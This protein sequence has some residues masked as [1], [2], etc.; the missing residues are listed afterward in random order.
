MRRALIVAAA[1]IIAPSAAMAEICDKG[2][3]LPVVF[4]VVRLLLSL[5]FVALVALGLRY[6]PRL[7]AAVL[8]ILLCYITYHGYLDWKTPDSVTLGMYEE[9]CRSP[10][11]DVRFMVNT[12]VIAAL[13]A[14]W[15]LSSWLTALS[16]FV[17]VRR[18]HRRPTDA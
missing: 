1:A 15:P 2:D 12:L 10:D 14:L 8:A 6:A 9:G 18:A 16:S 7:T 4:F 11:S 3:D 5:P 17:R 13:L